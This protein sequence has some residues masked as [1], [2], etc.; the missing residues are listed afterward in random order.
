M[1]NNKK[2]NIIGTS[3]GILM[4]LIFLSI[5]VFFICSNRETNSSMYN[6]YHYQ[7]EATVVYHEI[8]Y[9]I[10]GNMWDV[11]SKKKYVSILEYKG[12]RHTYYT[13][14]FFYCL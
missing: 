12:V 4:I 1:K 11:H 8:E 6:I 7:D 2:K 9:E 3:F 14:D 10:K 13:Y 5:I